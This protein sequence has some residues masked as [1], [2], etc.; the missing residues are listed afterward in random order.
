[1]SPIV[2]DLGH[3]AEFED[4]W[5]VERLGEVVRES[6]L[7]ETF[8]AMRTPRSRR[9]EL[10][11]PGC[12]AILD[13]LDDVRRSTLETL[14]RVDLDRS[15]NRLLADGYVY[16]LVRQHEAQ[17][18]ETILQTISLME[19]ESY[20]PVARRR[21]ESPGP[22]EVGTMVEVPAG[23]FDMGALA[24]TFAY[25][26][27]LPR[28]RTRTDAFEIGRF[29]VT[30]GEYVEFMAA[31]GYDDRT[32]WTDAGLHWK[33]KAGPA[34]PKYWRPRA[35]SRPFSSVDAAEV[36]RAG[37]TAAWE[38]I[39][40]LGAEP[41]EANSPVIHGSRHRGNAALSLGR[42]PPER[43]SR[44]PRCRGVRRGPGRRFSCRSQ[45]GGM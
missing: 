41:V 12:A 25:D 9:G 43:R 27:E 16:E 10:D 45:S 23:S 17:H 22:V 42:T 44:Q 2:W 31:G 20:V 37:G 38:R 40:S 6:A 14:S 34:A 26:N 28:H 7:P 24:G 36:A 33:Q 18:Q 4:L 32:L 8:D 11:L 19:T 1:M 13:R 21:F 35:L 30:N 5:L 29:P 3:I 39:T 15:D